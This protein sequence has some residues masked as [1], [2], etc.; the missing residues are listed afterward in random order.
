MYSNDLAEF[1]MILQLAIIVFPVVEYPLSQY[2]PPPLPLAVLLIR[3]VW[4]ASDGPTLNAAL[5][6]TAALEVAFA[7]LL[8]TGLLV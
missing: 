6:R 7:V 2:T 1:L 5:A 4:T 8:A 3:T